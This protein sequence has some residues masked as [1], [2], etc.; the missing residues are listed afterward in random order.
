MKTDHKGAERFIKDKEALAK[1][2]EAALHESMPDFL[3]CKLTCMEL[4]RSINGAAAQI[5][6]YKEKK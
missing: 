2:R 1:W 6:L 3:N 5:Q 4:F